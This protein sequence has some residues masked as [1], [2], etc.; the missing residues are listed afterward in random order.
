MD[1]IT[2]PSPPQTPCVLW[3]GYVN[4][5]GYGRTGTHESAHRAAYESA[6]GS[7][8]AG[9]EVDHLCRTP[10]CVNPDHLEA[11]TKTINCLRGMSFAAVNHRKDRCDHGHPFDEANTYWRPNG[12]RDCRQCIRDRAR[13][14]AARQRDRTEVAA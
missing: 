12:N 10:L 7:I 1:V 6:K 3:A 14:Y 2:V 8:P 4:T 13:A 9:M 11:V 5:D